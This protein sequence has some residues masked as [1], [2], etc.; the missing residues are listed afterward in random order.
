MIE[1]PDSTEECGGSCVTGRDVER[2]C[3]ECKPAVF[4]PYG[5]FVIVRKSGRELMILEAVMEFIMVRRGEEAAT[6]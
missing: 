6:K 3:L 4:Q 1:D 5:T 2:H